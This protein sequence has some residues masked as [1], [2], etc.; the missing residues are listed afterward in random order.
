MW[1]ESSSDEQA[2]NDLNSYLEQKYGSIQTIQGTNYLKVRSA[3]DI[4]VKLQNSNGDDLP[5]YYVKMDL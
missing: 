1:Y 4:P 5:D 3:D 2:A